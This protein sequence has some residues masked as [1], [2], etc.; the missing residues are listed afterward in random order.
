VSIGKNTGR[1]GVTIDKEWIELDQADEMFCNRR[2]TGKVV[3]GRVGDAA[4]QQTLCDDLDC[5]VAGA[6]DVKG[7]RVT[8][9]AV[10]LGMT[11]A[12][13]EVD[14]AELAKFSKGVG[15]LVVLE[16]G[17]IPDDAPDEFDDEADGSLAIEG[18]W[19]NVNLDEL[20]DPKK[21]IRKAFAKAGINT[22]GEYTEWCK[23][24]GDFWAKD[25]AGVGPKAQ[26]EIE[27]TFVKFWKDNP[28][29]KE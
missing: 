4:N 13:A 20:F 17:E 1:I 28:N 3:L 12:L 2:L 19:V 10:S 27:D 24:K 14:I 18:P 9:S 23:K 21:S 25:L 11:F 22:V 6:F 15:R 8:E 5:Q 7:F 16:V 26:Q 29:A